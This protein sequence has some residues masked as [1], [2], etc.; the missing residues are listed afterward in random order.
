MADIR[1]NGASHLVGQSGFLVVIIRGLQDLDDPVGES[2]PRSVSSIVT[3]P[4]TTDH[5][6]GS[7]LLKTSFDN[8]WVVP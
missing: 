1:H 4:P 7:S 6:S 5:A 3:E 8:V 2:G